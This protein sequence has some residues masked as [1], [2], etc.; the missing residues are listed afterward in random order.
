MYGFFI[1]KAELEAQ[2]KVT[3]QAVLNE[4]R[5]RMIEV[6][7]NELHYKQGL[8]TIENNPPPALLRNS[9]TTA[10]FDLNDAFRTNT[11]K[12]TAKDI[13]KQMHQALNPEYYGKNPSRSFRNC[14]FNMMKETNKALI[15]ERE[16]QSRFR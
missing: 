2:I 10:I 14:I 5:S 8:I 12:N 7:I 4:L 15:S 3:E 6:G 16:M 1:S 9:R 13:V 11:I